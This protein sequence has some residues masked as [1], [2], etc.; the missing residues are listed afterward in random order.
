MQIRPS[1][2]LNFIL[3]FAS[4]LLSKDSH[5]LILHEKTR[6]FFEKILSFFY[7][8]AKMFKH[9]ALVFHS[10][11]VK[12]YLVF[13]KKSAVFQSLRLMLLLIPL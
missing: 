4:F 10:Y 13:Y 7:I 6:G 3:L 12:K 8:L 5:F 9:F 11:F 1:F 2:R